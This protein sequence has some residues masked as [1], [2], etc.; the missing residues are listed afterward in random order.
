[1]RG[2]SVSSD[3]TNADLAARLIVGLAG[4]VL[5]APEA[6]WLAHFRPAGVILFS[7]NC[8]DRSQ[9]L[10]LC[11]NLRALVP[12]L[13]IMADH[14]G[15]PV[16]VLARVIGRPPVAWTLGQLDD[17]SLT[18]AVHAETGRRL[19]QAG[20]DRVLAPVADVL[21]EPR[22]PVIA[23]RAFGDR[24]DLVARQ[25]AAA[26]TGLI[27][28][29]VKVCLKHWPGHGASSSD[30]HLTAALD[31]IGTVGEPFAAG[32]AAGA[33]AVMVGHLPT[34][35]GLPA[36][37]DREFLAVSRA[38]WRSAQTGEPRL[39][40]DDITMG[41]LREPMAR[42]GVALA[43]GERTG[44]ID[45]QYLTTAWLQALAGGGCDQL[46]VRG[47]P[48]VALPVPSGVGPLAAAGPI[49]SSDLNFDDSPY[50]AARQRCWETA[51]AGFIAPARDLLWWD[52]TVGDRWLVAGGDLGSAREQLAS[53]LRASFGQIHIVG[54]T[55]PDQ[56]PLTRLLVTSHR[57]LPLSV[58]GV[59]PLADTGV[60]LVMGHPSLA[61]AMTTYLGPGWQVGAVYDVTAADLCL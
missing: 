8:H 22:N 16:S 56:S 26:V 10:N 2:P 35:A 36:T 30:T 19:R 60:C 40:A 41:G 33:D 32:L 23:A 42:L 44:M 38:T 20:V 21:S 7:R 57:P 47:I 39:L 12:G 49:A 28:A 9:L 43:T 55:D 6:V 17:V 24:T 58:S 59:R 45:P 37:L 31:G 13:E 25:V 54:E 18:T 50:V 15:G 61:T 29:G 3:L 27:G 1:M 46:L 34:A 14:E 52:L 51:S 48:F 5:T 53:P 4:T 11:R